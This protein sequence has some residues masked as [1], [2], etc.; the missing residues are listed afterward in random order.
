[1]VFWTSPWSPPSHIQPAKDYAATPFSSAN[2]DFVP[3]AANTLSP[4]KLSLQDTPGRPQ[5]IPVPQ[6]THIPTSSHNPF[7]QTP[8]AHVTTHT[9]MTLLTKPHHHTWSVTVVLTA[10]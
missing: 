7:P 5:A 10:S 9:Q 8:L 6:S 2:R 4:F 3:A 1:M